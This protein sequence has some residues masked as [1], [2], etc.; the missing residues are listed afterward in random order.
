MPDRVAESLAGERVEALLDLGKA[1]R[2]AYADRWIGSKT[3]A[4][5][6]SSLGETTA[7]YLKVKPHGLPKS[8]I[9]GQAI[10]CSI[11]KKPEFASSSDFDALAAYIDDE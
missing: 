9:P 1:G 10:L 7:N 2:R 8:A 3:Q 11:E 6:E 4:V 5:L